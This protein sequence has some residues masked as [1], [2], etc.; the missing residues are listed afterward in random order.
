MALR[1]W[2]GVTRQVSF[3]PV[4]KGLWKRTWAVLYPHPGILVASFIVCIVVT[5]SDKR[6]TKSLGR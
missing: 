3:Y 5:R 2:L 1:S 4:Q 6:G